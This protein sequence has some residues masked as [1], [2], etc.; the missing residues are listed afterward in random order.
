MS[1]TSY[2]IHQAIG[3]PL[4]FKGLKAQYIVLA[5][6]ALVGDL[7]LFVILSIAKCNSI[8]DI[9]IAFGL[10]AAAISTAYRL[11]IKYGEFG[12]MKKK[13]RK[14]VPRHIRCDSRSIFIQLKKSCHGPLK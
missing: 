3:R 13:A 11:S 6:A 8:L 12:F 9:I 14:K 10:G 2:P 4:I 1:P 7:V 5:A